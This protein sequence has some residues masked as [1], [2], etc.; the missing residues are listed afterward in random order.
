VKCSGGVLFVTAV[1]LLLAPAPLR[2]E[3]PAHL[4]IDGTVKD[5]EGTP[6]AGA[7]VY[8][9]QSDHSGS[10]E[11]KTDPSGKFVFS[12]RTPGTYILRVQ[13]PGFNE[14][15]ETVSVPLVE[16]NS[17]RVLLVRS[18]STREKSSEAMQLS[19]DTNFKV[20]G[21]TDWTAAG[22][23][24][25]DVS[26]RTSEA[27]AKET[28]GL[29]GGSS[30]ERNIR[31]LDQL[32]Q[33]RDQLQKE[34]ATHASA[35]LHRQLGDVDEELN[36]PLGAEQEYER[37][38]QIEP[39]EANYFSWATELLSHRA[40]QPAMEVF[41]KGATAYPRSER[42]LAGLGAAL[43][44]S[45]LYTQ[46]AEKLCAASDVNPRDATPYLFLGRMAQASAQPLPCA[47]KKFARF[48]H[49]QPR[50]AYANFYY[51]LALWKRSGSSDRATVEQVESLLK[52]ATSANPKLA[53]AY[54]QLGV[55]YAET[56]DLEDATAAYEKA[57]VANP[58]L[59][60]AHFRLA[61]AYK[62]SGEIEKAQHEFQMYEQLQKSQAAAVEQQRREIQ[63]FVVVF[64]DQ[65][66]NSA[67]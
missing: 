4:T 44:A 34:L 65:Q 52:T 25:S 56:G 18:E 6:V 9:E 3:Q 53:D 13:K 64:K 31:N 43:Y 42:M 47:E 22:G 45:G 26:L 39:S 2:A 46:A 35:D 7:L 59:A 62:K 60:E 55:I 63:Q 23:H 49:D 67:N 61:Q 51:A 38:T 17:C 8:I 50:N 12:L 28:R 54:L 36:D 30:G 33:T 10:T 15:R 40:I 48:S 29:Q 16:G 32:R 58:D 66:K 5:A 11:T 27:L 37:A 14:A 1:L 57:T 41:T 21:I 19:D 24:G 20:A